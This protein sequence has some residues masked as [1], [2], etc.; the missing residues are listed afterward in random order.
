MRGFNVTFE[1]FF[2]HEPEED[3][4]EADESGFEAENVSL[5]DAIKYA[6]GIRGNWEANEWPIRSPRWFTNASYN[7]GTCEFYEQGITESRS[8]HIPE[9]VTGA[10]RRRIARLLGCKV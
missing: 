1:R 4:C 8:L 2:P 10:S 5:R 3:I 9:H 6:G 7:D